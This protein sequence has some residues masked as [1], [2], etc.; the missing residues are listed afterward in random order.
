MI[1]QPGPEPHYGLQIF[2]PGNQFPQATI[3]CPDEDPFTTTF[4]VPTVVYTE[5]PEQAAVRGTYQGSGSFSNEFFNVSFNW[6]LT[7][8]EAPSP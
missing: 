1:I 2:F 7:D 6:N 3:N 8:P 5:D 4:P